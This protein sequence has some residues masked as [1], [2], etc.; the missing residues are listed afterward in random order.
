V[1]RGV[2][3]GC[4]A[5]LL[6]ACG[7]SGSVE[8]FPVTGWTTF[9]NGLGRASDA[10]GRVSLPI[11]NLWALK[12]PGHITAQPIVVRGAP[13][14]HRATVYVATSAGIV[15]AISDTGHPIWRVQLG[16]LASSCPQL[17][18]YGVTGTPVA[19]PVT[20][21]LYVADALGRL[22]A[23]SLETGTERTGWP[24]RLYSDF[25]QELVWGALTAIRTSIY[26]GTG[27]YCD[28]PMVG[29][30]F[31]ANV[32]TGAVSHWD[33]VPQ[34]RGGGGSVWGW[35]GLAYSSS[36][37]S[38]LAVTGNAFRAGSN[39][40]DAFRE[41]EPYGEHLVELSLGLRVRSSNHPRDI[42]SD[43][44]L[45]FV[46][47]PVVVKRPGCPEE[48]VALNKNGRLYGWRTKRIGR[49]VTWM[50]RV[51]PS[52]RP[53]VTQAAYST[54]LRALFVAT[55]Q[56][57]V[58]VAVTP[59]CRGRIAWT[60][61]LGVINSTPTVA[62]STVWTVGWHST[63]ALIG[64]DGRTGHVLTRSPLGKDVY[65]LGPSVVDGRMYLASFGGLVRALE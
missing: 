56:G 35:G 33:V 44:D 63:A 4:A 42:D 61:Q 31:R 16:K 24:V 18:G 43:D 36:R 41:W 59:A 55:G 9:G 5:A 54:A 27:S 19:D 21:A 29:R 30:V 51:A 34:E 39:T 14:T 38:L 25:R 8:S 26:L 49:G 22:H 40:G 2:V 12:L 52:K 45:D 11:G 47:S 32:L 58:K 1:G 6:F 57:L 13:G 46:G 23:L 48:I 53:L 20:H 7:A 37:E 65:Y 62:G 10:R 3:P 17:P 50:L 28:A 60:R 64:I 15:E